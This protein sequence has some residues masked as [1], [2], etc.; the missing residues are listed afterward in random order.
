MQSFPPLIVEL[1]SPLPSSLSHPSLRSEDNR[2][3]RWLRGS[4]GD[5]DL[6]AAFVPRKHARSYVEG[7]KT[8]ADLESRQHLTRKKK[9][10]TEFSKMVVFDTRTRTG[11]ERTF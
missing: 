5:G 9:K 4:L 6:Q 1:P 3:S 7:K 2:T 8:R 11:T 10:P